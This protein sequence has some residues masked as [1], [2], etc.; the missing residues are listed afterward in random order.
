M[1]LPADLEQLSSADLRRLVA[2]QAQLLEHKEAQLRWHQAKI[3]KLT[4]E[5]ALHKRWRF[6][7]KTEHCIRPVNPTLKLPFP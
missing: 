1:F 4:H 5:L 6:G 2:S 3:D 7:V